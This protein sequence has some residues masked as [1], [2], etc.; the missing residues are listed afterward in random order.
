MS[1]PRYAIGL[2]PGRSTGVAIYDREADAIIHGET[3]DFWRV[4]DLLANY[5][6]D[7]AEVIAED[8]SL[9]KP[10]FR[11]KAGAGVQDRMARN[12]GA[13]QRESVLLIEG[14]RRLG[15]NVLAVRPQSSKWDDAMCRRVTGWNRRT[16][17]HVRDA[18]KLCFKANA[19]GAGVRAAA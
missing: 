19:I 10:T 9:N 15:Y 5:P 18:I 14:L 8:C 16:S 12:V 3:L 1:K 4:F 7:V 11:H 17:Q 13:V 6:P 2:D